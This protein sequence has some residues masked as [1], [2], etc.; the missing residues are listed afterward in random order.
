MFKQI[1]TFDLCSLFHF[2]VFRAATVFNRDLSKWDV[3]AV[4]NM[5]ESTLQTDLPSK[6]LLFLPCF[7]LFHFSIISTLHE[8]IYLY[9]QMFVQCLMNSDF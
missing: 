4:K 7:L 8:Y 2:L 9:F 5:R 1:L 6:D 3:G